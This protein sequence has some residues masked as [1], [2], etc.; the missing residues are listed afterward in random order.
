MLAAGGLLYFLLLRPYV[1]AYF[2]NIV[3]IMR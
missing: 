2:A 1:D 3:E